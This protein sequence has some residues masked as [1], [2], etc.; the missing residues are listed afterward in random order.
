MG[1]SRRKF[2][3]L[4]CGVDT[5]RLLEHYFVETALWLSVVSSTLGMLCVGCLETRLGRRLVPSDFPAVWINDPRLEPKSQR[6]L[7]RLRPAEE[8][9]A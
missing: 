2:L 7:S 3:C 4:D 6:L 1:R 8:L 9:A 5:G